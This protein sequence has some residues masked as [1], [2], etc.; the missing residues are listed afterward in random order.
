LGTIG[1]GLSHALFEIS[2]NIC[3]GMRLV[4]FHIRE[5]HYLEI[6]FLT[7]LKDKLASYTESY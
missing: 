5:G 1:S 2:Q 4:P 7:C 6:A 3:L